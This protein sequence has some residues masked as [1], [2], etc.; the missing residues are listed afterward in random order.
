MVIFNSYVSLPEGSGPQCL[1]HL[2]VPVRQFQREYR[3]PIL[4]HPYALTLLGE[5]LTA[6]KVV[7]FLR[8]LGSKLMG[9]AH[10]WVVP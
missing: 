2:S 7:F 8:I 1:D 9:R 4:V 10:N 3:S 5:A 6:A